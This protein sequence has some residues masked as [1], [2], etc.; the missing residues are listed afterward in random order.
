M[1]HRRTSTAIGEF[2]LG[3]A[4]LCM[5]AAMMIPLHAYADGNGNPGQTATPIQHL[6]VIFQENVSFDHYFATYPIALNP[7]GEPRFKASADTPTVNGLGTLVGGQPDGVL[8]THNPNANN[9]ANGSN[10]I[11]PFRLDRSQASTCDQ[12]HNYGD[13]QA[14]FD[15]GLMD[16]FPASVGTGSN[17]ILRSDY[18]WGKDKGLVMGYFDGN[19]VTALWNYAQQYAM[20]DNSYGTTFGPSTP[21]LMNLVAGNTYPATVTKNSTKG[22]VAIN[23]GV[24]TVVSDPDPDGDVCSAATRTQV[25][26]GGKNIGNL[27]NDKGV[28]WGAFMGGFDLSI[29]NDN[30]TTGCNRSSK[31]TAANNGPTKDYIPHHAFFQYWASTAN[32]QHKRP[33]SVWEIG[34]NGPANHEYDLHDFFDA[35]KVG[36]MPAVSFL[37]A[38]AAEDGHAGYSDPLLEQQFLVKTINT[39]MQSPFWRSTAIVIAY[40]DS[41]GWYD[42]QMSPIVN[43]SAVN[44]QGDPADSDQL[45]GPGKCGNGTPLKDDNGNPIQ[46]RCGYGPRLPLLV[47]SP[48]AKQN[49]VDNTLTDQSSVLRFVE[50][51][52]GTGEIGGGSF[53]QLAGPLANLFDFSRRAS[54]GRLILDPSTGQPRF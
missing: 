23:N 27:L 53:D 18:A 34:K 14:A 54:N 6:V 21:G 44:I 46:G 25:T 42:H 49:F 20:S 1:R 8:L 11:N 36:N 52:W 37:K 4:G 30:G 43:P 16:M 51:N 15:Q 50:D 29:T 33:N 13:E 19:T 35:L 41:D 26:M 40:D 12:D 32:P 7:S 24:G 39:I 9:P 47:I 3:A 22:I 28:T 10:A 2:A 48:Y 17:C 5:M 45:N 38:I 31:A